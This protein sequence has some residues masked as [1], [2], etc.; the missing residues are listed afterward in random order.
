VS[1]AD[2]ARWRF[3]LTRTAWSPS[4]TGVVLVMA[5]LL[6]VHFT[7]P[8]G[9]LSD[10]TYL[11][12]NGAAAALSW[13]GATRVSGSKALV[14]RLIATGLTASALGDLVWQVY[15]WA[16]AEPNVS[17]ADAA[18]LLAYA[19][20]GAALVVA[21]LLRTRSGSRVDPDTIIDA[22]TIIVVSVLVFWD[23]SIADIVADTSVSTFTR[24]VWA[25]Y[26]VL[27]AI[28]LAL[29]VRALVSKRSR[30]SIGLAFA[31]GISCWLVSD[32]GYLLLT[33]SGTTSSLL[34][35][36]W[37]LGALLMSTSA[38]RR[39]EPEAVD[40]TWSEKASDHPLW[41]LGMATVPLLIPLMIHAA[42]DLRGAEGHALATLV[43]VTLLLGLSF[44]RSARLL[45]SERHARTEARASRDAALEASRAKS[46]FVA[47]MSH[48]IRTPMNGVIGLT[49]LLQ[50][51]RLDQRQR[52]YV[53]GVHLAGEALLQIIND[54]L[55][56]SKVEAGKLELDIIDF[57]LVQ[58]V[59]EAAELVAEQA[60]GKGLELLAYCSPEVPLGV[61]GDPSRLRQVLLN[62]ASNAVK[63]TDTGEVVIRALLDDETEHGP[64]LRFEVTDT[65][66]GL[67]EDDRDRLFEPFSQA[68]SSTTRRFG[69]TGLGLAICR[70]LITAMGGALGVD[71]RLGR[72]STFWFTLPLQHAAGG[73]APLPAR[74]GRLADVRVLVVDDNA[75]NRLILSDQLG[76]WGMRVDLAGDGPT[77]L[78][79]LEEAVG[80][81]APYALVLLDLCMPGMDGL[82][83]A[84]RI[85]SLA[86]G[87]KMVLLSS[88]TD[89]SPAE[90]LAS[91]ITV[92]LTKP[93][94]MSR[95]QGTL[96]ELYV[97]PTS[98]QRNASPRPTDAG[99]GTRGHVLVVEDNH[100]N[101]LVAV[102]IL[103]YLGYTTEV[104]GNGLEAL[105][106]LARTPFAAVLMD[107]Q[108][109][110]MD[111]FA[112]T[113]EIRRIE[114]NGVRVPVIAMTAGVTEG[115]R[116]RC[117]SAGMDDF[118]AKPV[119][120]EELGATLARWIST[121]L[122]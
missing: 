66:V 85:Q 5:T 34:D 59:E 113:T 116:E 33:V 1:T 110:E 64:V 111:G 45:Q 2:L 112:A 73:A 31:A 11:V 121:S 76:A 63:F 13:I 57:N 8:P 35:V 15:T 101:Q 26:P 95:L 102:G 120:P 72:G 55:D 118:V 78:H 48:E 119:S 20:L 115:E 62:L 18:Y 22:L 109:P 32:L 90:A 89:L 114:R 104:A 82:A 65:G 54:I 10:L 52:Q 108:M 58:V 83:L 43:S 71:S 46:A 50:G 37:M 6:V 39:H 67:E 105:V 49:G 21:T 38:F 77:A 69:G 23:F 17:I 40:P 51:T 47:T 19:G 24:L 14:P 103:E 9:L 75:T 27:D 88:V 94:Q 7:A 97:A 56:F 86:S 61:R 117:F 81:D 96:E 25:A 80:T 41:K 70:Q 93:L 87:V 30:S 79:L 122:A 74:G 36:G 28:V 92:S 68:D 42:D 44:A 99:P 98:V 53:D 100:V 12:V 84:R 29:V 3:W 60:Q 106:S 91:G 4:T 16:G 107:C